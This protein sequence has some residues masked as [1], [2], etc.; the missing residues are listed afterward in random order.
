LP[1]KIFLRPPVLELRPSTAWLPLQALASSFV[2]HIEVTFF[3]VLILPLLP[4]P[5]VVPLRLN[6]TQLVTT[7]AEPRLTLPAL[8][9]PL[10][11]TSAPASS[12]PAKPAHSKATSIKPS[13]IFPG[14]QE[15]VSVPPHPD[16]LL[17]TVRQPDRP[18]PPRL[19]MPV[20]APN[21]LQIAAPVRPIL[22]PPLVVELQANSQKR[23][24]PVPPSEQ[25]AKA[26]LNLPVSGDSLNK[27]VNTLAANN[28]LQPKLAAQPLPA[29]VS[30][31]GADQ[32]N[33]LVLN[34]LPSSS[35]A[36]IPAGE[37]AGTF[38]VS[39]NPESNPKIIANSSSGTTAGISGPIPPTKS[40]SEN[41][42]SLGTGT[43]PAADNH[44]KDNHA[45]SG[46]GGGG[47]AVTS[48]TKNDREGNVNLPANIAIAHTP[49]L[50]TGNAVPRL[51]IPHG[52]Y[53]MTIVSNG[54]TGGG[55]KDYGVFK[56]E[57]VY[58]VYVQMS[59]PE[60]PRSNW[61]LQY[62]APS[63]P[64]STL[65]SPPFPIAKEY[66]KLPR[67][68]AQRNIGTSI[69]VTGTI[70]KDGKFESLRIIQSPNPLLIQ[71]VLDCL[72][73]W[74]FQAAE[75]NGEAVTVKFL[76]GIPVALD[77]EEMK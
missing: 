36:D 68:V 4:S 32:R 65:L 15:I 6:T 75:M 9:P 30:G 13:L 31:M 42:L 17:Q 19:K 20:A 23:I 67:E 45:N 5:R 50:P 2:L 52:I 70:T 57:V 61:T 35:P 62:A 44:P 73:K 39:P 64:P 53:G 14:P 37:L 47:K 25:A 41:T 49:S 58:T 40:G 26:R 59:E 12:A 28:T 63:L 18:T 66:P 48:A 76:L 11:A 27:S 77:P 8:T 51:A 10:S 16:N 60:R 55:L 46:L 71:P 1:P 56:N 7:Q 74:S 24:T 3:A 22:A 43:S 21:I 69:V 34:A 29:S 38:V 33:L 72:A 54:S